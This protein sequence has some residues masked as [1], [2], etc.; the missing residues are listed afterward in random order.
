MQC[1]R[2]AFQHALRRTLFSNS[3]PEP[4]ET[5]RHS[6]ETRSSSRLHLCSITDPRALLPSFRAAQA[7]PWARAVVC[8]A[9]HH[10]TQ[11]TGTF[12][13]NSRS[14]T[15]RKRKSCPNPKMASRMVSG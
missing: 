14:I 4:S 2:G 9:P 15:R 8:P 11:C 10:P 7:V 5:R 1:L 3:L 12:S 13:D 6:P